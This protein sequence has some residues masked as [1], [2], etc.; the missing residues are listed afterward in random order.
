MTKSPLSRESQGKLVQ[1]QRKRRSLRILEKE[2]STTN[3]SVTEVN[4]GR[5]LRKLRAERGF[6][7]R[8][9]AVQSG[10]N[11]NTLS[12]IENGKTSP[13][14]STLQQLAMTLDIP[15]T[16]FFETETPK[17]TIAYQ[18]AGHRPR[19]AFAHGWLEDLGA[20]LT[21]HGADPF[22]ITLEPNADSGDTSIVHTGREFVFCLEGHLLYTIENDTFLLEPGDSLLFEAHLPHR[23]RNADASPSRS[24][25]IFSLDDEHDRPTKHH[26]T[27]GRHPRI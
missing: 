11:V 14:V 24:L 27:L 22:V 15:I 21:S 7:I 5:C 6:S 8:A 2:H 17:K 25:L 9:L 20:G 4:V 10:L 18:K 1:R 19:A 26:F 13:S 16:A 23:W 12:L 3:P